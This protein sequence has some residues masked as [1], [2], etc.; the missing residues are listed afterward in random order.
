MWWHPVY[1]DAAEH[2]YLRD[3]V[4]RA[5]GIAHRCGQSA[6]ASRTRAVSTNCSN[7]TISPARTMK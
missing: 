1:D 7:R 3:L 5:K 6:M 4:E 2:R